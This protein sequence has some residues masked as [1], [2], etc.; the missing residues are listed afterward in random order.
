MKGGKKKRRVAEKPSEECSA[1]PGCPLM[2]RCADGVVDCRDKSL[3]RI[4]PY[5]PDSATELRLEQNQITEIPAKAFAAYKKLKRVDLSN[6]QI[7]SIAGDAFHGL[8]SLT[9]LILYGNRIT[10]LPAGMFHGLTSLQL[11]LLNANRISCVRR[12][13][14]KD[15]HNLNL[16]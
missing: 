15:L 14:F 16:L 8:K 3:S 9:S 2:C 1:Q 4:P 11:L 10:E 13:S 6:N 12:D 7:S 5:L